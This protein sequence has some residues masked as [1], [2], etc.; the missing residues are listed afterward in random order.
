MAFGCRIDGIEVFNTDL[1]EL[2]IFNFYILKTDYRA[3]LIRSSVPESNLQIALP[4][5]HPS[6][7][8]ARELILT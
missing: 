1:F 6:I 4:D 8:D 7:R 2:R 5:I 3:L